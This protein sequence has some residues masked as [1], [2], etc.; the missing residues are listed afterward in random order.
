[1]NTLN[2]A[3]ELVF[4][5]R[6][7]DKPC[8]IGDGFKLSYAEL[9]RAV[10]RQAALLSRAGV[11]PG[12]C[13]VIS[14]D[15]GPSLVVI[16]FAALAIAALPV[17][18]NS[19]LDAEPLRQ[20]LDDAEPALVYAPTQRE[21]V[22]SEALQSLVRAVPAFFLGA[23]W[24]R[25]LLDERDEADEWDAM[26][27]VDGDAP[28]LIQYT[29]GTTG[30]AKGVMH[31]TRG[32][33]ECCAAFVAQLGLGPDDVL[34]SVPKTFFGYGMGN[35]LFFPLYLGATA[36]LDPAW[37]TA[38]SVHANLRRFAP[39]VLFAVPTMYRLL[40]DD[41]L[42]ASDCRLRLA[43]SAGAPLPEVIATRWRS[44]LGFD[45]HDGIG[46]T[47]LC[48]V[49]ATS[50]PRALRA[51]SIGQLLPGCAARI[52]D[53]Q[54]RE[55]SCGEVGVLY[56]RAPFIAAGYWRRPKEQSERFVDGW[57]RTGDL[58]RQDRDG[59][60]YFHG[61][62][63]DR[64]KVFGRWV[65]PV[66]IEGIIG[67]HAPTIGVCFVVPGRD[68]VGEDR[69]V[70]CVHGRPDDRQLDHLLV[71]LKQRMESHAYPARVLLIDDLPTT[72]NGKPNRRALANLATKALQLGPAR[73]GWLC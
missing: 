67:V 7:L 14:L 44:R 3:N 35:S 11:A 55:V 5:R 41:G 61:R 66:E 45:L 37:P 31:S 13:V 53:E 73:E 69:P 38:E 1:M 72:P 39:T 56:M 16:F 70:L 64:F 29:S 25:L 65:T 24:F 30:H 4:K 40:L 49:F 10:R 52:V 8:Y 51:G 60:L 22:V 23:D 62:E 32:V 36:V 17:V 58:F 2:L 15:D 21:A 34:Y 42:Q 33:L 54:G 19:R 28:A 57:Y 12:D 46:S 48:H 63:D 68:A 18:V 47:E 27:A 20:I 50:Y 6:T 71:L 59:F 26:V 43:L 9:D